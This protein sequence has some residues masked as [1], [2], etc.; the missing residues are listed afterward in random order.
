MGSWYAKK[1]RNDRCFCCQLGPMTAAI[2]LLP[3]V[4]ILHLLGQL[5][6]GRDAVDDVNAEHCHNVIILEWLKL[7]R[8][9]TP[10]LPSIYP[11]GHLDFSATILCSNNESVASRWGGGGSDLHS[12][13]GR[14]AHPRESTEPIATSHPTPTWTHG[15]G[16]H[17]QKQQAR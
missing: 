12:W 8:I 16:P 11:G 6:R 15:G 9:D 4:I 14:T 2:R 13:A 10:Q 3:W 5:G 1:C 17:S 7:P